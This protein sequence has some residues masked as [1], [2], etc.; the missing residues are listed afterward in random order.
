MLNV[1]V[2]RNPW[3]TAVVTFLP[4]VETKVTFPDDGWKGLGMAS[5]NELIFT[6]PGTMLGDVITGLEKG[7][8]KGYTRMPIVPYVMFEAKLVPPFEKLEKKLKIIE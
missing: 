4:V 2:F 6:F 5:D 3:F 1:P 7:R 8:E